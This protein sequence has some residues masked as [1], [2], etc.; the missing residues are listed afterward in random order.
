MSPGC[1]VQYT[2]HVG[3][4][5]RQSLEET[6]YSK[7]NFLTRLQWLTV[8]YVDYTCYQKGTPDTGTASGEAVLLA[9]GQ[10]SYV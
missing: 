10:M 6:C 4:L 7:G 8:T 3:V 1:T 2:V 9:V 5:G